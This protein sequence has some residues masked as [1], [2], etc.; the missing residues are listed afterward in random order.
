MVSE[1]ATGL[2]IF[3]SMMDMAK[4]LK[5][6]NDATIRN[7][8]VIE[9]QEKILAAQSAQAMLVQRVGDLEKEVAGLKD[10]KTEKEKYQLTEIS[11]G[12]F[13]YVIKSA[14]QNG[15][16]VHCLCSNCY[17]QG[18]KSILNATYQNMSNALHCHLCSALFSVNVKLENTGHFDYAGHFPEEETMA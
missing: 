9:L 11:P 12:I 5:D 10:W 7:S 13:A 1:F 14:M 18:K 16:P 4:G 8:A 6:A 3:K 17:Q 15:E 2:G